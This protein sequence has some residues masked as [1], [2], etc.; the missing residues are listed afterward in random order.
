MKGLIALLLIGTPLLTRNVWAEEY[1]AQPTKLHQA[2]ILSVSESNG[3]QYNGINESE[4]YAEERKAMKRIEGGVA[5]L[6]TSS[7]TFSSIQLREAISRGS[8]SP[9][10][11][12]E[13][14][15]KW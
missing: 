1:L 7:K 15:L 13:L 9:I 5:F 4:R 11:G 6:S 12:V 14:E 2:S 3:Y 8:K 10:V